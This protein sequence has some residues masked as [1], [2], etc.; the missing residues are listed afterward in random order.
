MSGE[1]LMHESTAWLL[2]LGLATI[3]A[4]IWPVAAIGVA[5]ITA[6]YTVALVGYEVVDALAGEDTPARIASHLPVLL[7]LVFTLLVARERAGSRRPR[8]S[9]ADAEVDRPAQTTAS[10]TAR[11]R[12]H[13]WPIN[14]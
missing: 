12:G 2:A 11:R 1:H 13:L 6:V 5:A 8:S 9:D 4:G 14:R 10:H 3:A 7:G